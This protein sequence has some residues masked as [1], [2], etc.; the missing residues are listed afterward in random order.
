MKL[1]KF[2]SPKKSS[3]AV[4]YSELRLCVLFNLENHLELKIEY[5]HKWQQNKHTISNISLCMA[6]RHLIRPA[7]GSIYAVYCKNSD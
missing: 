6:E 2:S 4:V 7:P 1:N 3:Y 5:L